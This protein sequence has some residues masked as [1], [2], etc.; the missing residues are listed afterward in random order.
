MQLIT[1]N[2]QTAKQNTTIEKHKILKLSS[3]LKSI[4]PEALC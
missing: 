4:F 3:M 2:G 1:D